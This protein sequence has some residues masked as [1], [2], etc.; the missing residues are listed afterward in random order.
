MGVSNLTLDNRNLKELHEDVL[1]KLP[2]YTPEYSFDW[3]TGDFG[4]L[5]TRVFM[6]MFLGTLHRYNQVPIKHYI[7]FLNMMNVDSKPPNS[8]IGPVV[9]EVASSMFLDKSTSLLV[10]GEAKKEKPFELLEPMQLTHARLIGLYQINQNEDVINDLTPYMMGQDDSFQL[11]D[12]E[13]EKNEQI[14]VCYFKSSQLSHR[15]THTFVEL[16]FHGETIEEEADFIALIEKED[17]VWQTN[18][19]PLEVYDF[20]G[21]RIRFILKDQYLEEGQLSCRLPLKEKESHYLNRVDIRTTANAWITPDV[22]FAN[23]IQ[24]VEDEIYPFTEILQPYNMFYISSE[25]VLNKKNCRVTLSFDYGYED[26]IFYQ[27]PAPTKFKAVMKE[28]EFT[29]ITKTESYI[30]RMIWEYWN[31]LRWC[32]LEI[33]GVLNPF[34][35]HCD[36]STHYEMT[37]VCPQDMVSYSVNGVLGPWIRG[38]I[39]SLSNASKPYNTYKVPK[40]QKVGLSFEYENVMPIDG[41]RI[42][43][44]G[45]FD[46]QDSIIVYK[47]IDDREKAVYFCFDQPLLYGPIHLLVDAEHSEERDFS[48]W[49]YSK[50]GW[51]PLQVI[52][53]TDNLMTIGLISFYG[54]EDISAVN[55][56]GLE[57]YWLRLVVEDDIEEPVIIKGIH[58]N[59]N[60]MKQQET[61]INETL[62]QVKDIEGMVFQTKLYPVVNSEVWVDE[63][64]L[65]SQRTR[66]L[67]LTSDDYTI[68]TGEGQYWVKWQAVNDFSLSSLDDRHYQIDGNQG[69]IIFSDGT[70]AKKPPHKKIKIHYSVVHGEEGNFEAYAD[71]KLKQ[72]NTQVTHIYNP[73]P[74]VNGSVSET[75]DDV[76]NR[77]ATPFFHRNR[78]ITSW[79]MEQMIFEYTTHILKVKCFSSLNKTLDYEPGHVLL[80]MVLKDSGSSEFSFEMLERSLKDYI[81]STSS[82]ELSLS[83]IQA[84]PIVMDL[85]L[86]VYVEAGVSIETVQQNIEK[87]IDDFLNVMTGGYDGQG[88][89]IGCLPETSMI[90][91]VVEEEVAVV[92]I[93]RLLVQMHET[94]PQG[95][96]LIEKAPYGILSK[97]HYDIKFNYLK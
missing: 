69:R 83:M 64:D 82:T 60:W 80:V 27:E 48:W 50:K 90:R 41:I 89:D 68:E 2:F 62:T 84:T 94:T 56:F 55:Y 23:D 66:E 77:G 34:A 91:H 47:P 53:H 31:G 63:Y 76:L 6:K 28:H 75:S 61:V 29:E 79:D 46:E 8:A 4:V 38:R 33:S 39:I 24:C 59:G 44:N 1:E 30:K 25:E 73:L 13:S 26:K 67:M 51:Q 93:K 40:V 3:T 21:N 36:E 43:E 17:V 97:G 37:F 57:G 7:E 11:L 95:N 70:I 16:Y 65:L 58:I 10:K 88:W 78:A 22:M 96:K 86:E 12:F 87:R 32:P 35:E 72:Q 92:S 45:T 9:F 18:D 42:E 52:D 14:H 49:Y 20:E 15:H 85:L 74:C 81:A 54:E 19:L 71:I 5:L